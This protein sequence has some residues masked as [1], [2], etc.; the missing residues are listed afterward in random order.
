METAQFLVF[1]CCCCRCRCCCCTVRQCWRLHHVTL[2]ELTDTW[3]LDG[4]GWRVHVC[5]SLQGA[6]PMRSGCG[7]GWEGVFNRD[8]KQQYKR[9]Q[10]PV[11]TNDVSYSTL[12]E[13]TGT[14]H[15]HSQTSR[16]WSEDF[17][18]LINRAEPSGHSADVQSSAEQCITCGSGRLTKIEKNTV[19]FRS[20]RP[21]VGHGTRVAEILAWA[22]LKIPWDKCKIS[23]RTCL[24]F[25]LP[26][27][28]LNI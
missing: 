27:E 15:I 28:I 10:A 13:R 3:H 14:S 6:Q 19:L 7:G 24:E 11:P 25:G 16:F 22:N 2:I 17:A 18:D 8:S 1:S 26:A 12:I 21:G 4:R 5:C 9:Y 20:T 23:A